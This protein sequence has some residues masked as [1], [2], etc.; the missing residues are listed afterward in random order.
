[1]ISFKDR[2]HPFGCKWFKNS[3]TVI[4]AKTHFDIFG[5]HIKMSG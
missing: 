4:K 2:E 3:R 1:M 5:E